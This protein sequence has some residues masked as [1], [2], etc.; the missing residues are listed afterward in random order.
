MSCVS[1]P[2]ERS[3][4]PGTNIGPKNGCWALLCVNSRLFSIFCAY[5]GMGCSVNSNVQ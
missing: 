4:Q 1:N 2:G 5:S 3:N